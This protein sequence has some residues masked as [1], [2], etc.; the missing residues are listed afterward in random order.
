[1]INIMSG[2]QI[3]GSS[4]AFKSEQQLQLKHSRWLVPLCFLCDLIVVINL[5]IRSGGSS[6]RT[7]IRSSTILGLLILLRLI[8]L[9]LLIRLL[10]ST[11]LLL[12]RHIVL[13]LLLILHVGV[14]ISL[15]VTRLLLIGVLHLVIVA[16]SIFRAKKGK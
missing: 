4:T 12:R 14:V 10:I 9:L 15:I 7:C 3:N 5:S 6:P 16:L 1:M 2:E 13:L 8:L 11:V